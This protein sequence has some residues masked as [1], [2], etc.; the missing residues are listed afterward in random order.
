MKAPEPHHEVWGPGCSV[1]VP[2]GALEV[3]WCGVSLA[4]MVDEEELYWR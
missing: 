1:P 3:L 4:G 2:R